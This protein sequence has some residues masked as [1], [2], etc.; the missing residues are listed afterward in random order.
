[1]DR[2]IIPEVVNDVPSVQSQL[3]EVR[4]RVHEEEHM[5]C[6][7]W[8]H[9][10]LNRALILSVHDDTILELFNQA[11]VNLKGIRTF[12]IEQTN[13]LAIVQVGGSL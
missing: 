3:G 6:P 11:P 5:R 1:M 13:S 10:H 7:S 8:R 12:R 4:I 9:S 2:L